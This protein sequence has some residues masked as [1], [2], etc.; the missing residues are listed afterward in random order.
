MPPVTG[1]TALVSAPLRVRALPSTA[2]EEARAL[3]EEIESGLGGGESAEPVALSCSWAWT[4]TWLTQYG[5][6]VGHRF[7]VG[8]HDGRAVGMALLTEAPRRPLRPRAI[9]LGTAGEPYGETVF[10]ER[11]RLLVADAQ[12]P[13][14]ATA[15]AAYVAAQRGWDRLRL[16]GLHATDADLLLAALPG[17]GL[18]AA[19]VDAQDS[20][21]ADLQE[22]DDVLAGLS[23]SRRQ[24]AR[25]SLKAFGELT[26]DWAETVA[27]ADAILAELIELHQQRWIEEGKRGAFASPRF[28]AF[29][30]ALVARML[31]EGRV[32]LLRVRRGEETVG[33]L[34][35]LVEDGRL[36]FYQSGLRRYEDNKLRAGVAAHVC[37]MRACRERGLVTYDFLAP[38]ARYKQDLSSRADRLVWAEVE[39]RTWRTALT[40]VAR[41]LR[42]TR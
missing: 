30:R 5:A 27:D 24:R 8:E 10:V 26:C 12:R 41:R 17:A 36:L 22:G 35:G 23:S 40:R 3:W 11:N 33:C 16:D 25:R 32:A 13:A 9:H 1:T 38:D 28:V 7:L 14:F 42:S 6:V 37:F 21:I 4:E 15:V 18:P 34:Y 31:P 2:R 20:P 39:R 29:H 19:V